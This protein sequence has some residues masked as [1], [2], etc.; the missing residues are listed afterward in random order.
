MKYIL[1]FMGVFIGMIIVIPLL[2]VM[3]TK[4]MQYLATFI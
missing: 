4:W 3:A 1:K 2:G